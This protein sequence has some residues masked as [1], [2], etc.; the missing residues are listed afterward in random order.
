MQIRR[1]KEIVASP[2]NV[3]VI[4]KGKPVWIESINNQTNSAYVRYLDN[5]ERME[6]PVMELVENEKH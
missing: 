2:E 6:V 5:S 1:A 3:E 4:Y